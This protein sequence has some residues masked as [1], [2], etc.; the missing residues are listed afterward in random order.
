MEDFMTETFLSLAKKAD[1]LL[2]AKLEM[3]AAKE[4]AVSD[5]SASLAS[6]EK[7]LTERESLIVSQEKSLQSREE[8]VSRKMAVVRADHEVRSDMDTVIHIKKENEKILKDAQAY[9]DEAKQK[10]EDLARRELALSEKEKTYKKEV[11]LE[12]M[13]HVAF[14]R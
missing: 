14:G 2:K 3:V 1:E 11:E 7:S 12:V 10:L 5:K 4:Q 9:R 8:E 13:R 6:L